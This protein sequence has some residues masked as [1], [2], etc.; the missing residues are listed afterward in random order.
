MRL[1][2]VVRERSLRRADHWSRGVLPTVVHR[3]VGSRNLVNEEAVPHWGLSRQKQTKQ[4]SCSV[5]NFT[6]RHLQLIARSRSL[7]LLG[8]YARRTVSGCPDRSVTNGQFIRR[9]QRHSTSGCPGRTGT[10]KSQN[11]LSYMIVASKALTVLCPTTP[12]TSL[13][14]RRHG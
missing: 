5:S 10:H 14:N 11:D 2:C 4:N 3:C 9:W 12:N 6:T 8:M 13:D 1:L 7:R